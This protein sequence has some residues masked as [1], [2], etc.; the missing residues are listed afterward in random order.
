ML[1]LIIMV[2]I[3]IIIII[4]PQDDFRWIKLNDLF[5]IDLVLI[6]ITVQHFSSI[7]AN[8]KS[9]LNMYCNSTIVKDTLSSVWLA[10]PYTTLH[11]VQE[12]RWKDEGW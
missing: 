7:G 11:Y 5:S 1:H 9:R 12:K 8:L 2:V 6:W 10:S 3:I 4:L